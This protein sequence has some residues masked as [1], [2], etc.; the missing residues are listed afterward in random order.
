MMKESLAPGLSHTH[1]YTVSP[2]KTVPHLY[3]EAEELQVMPEV[4]AT[5]YLVGLLEWACIRAINPFIDWPQE[6]TV[7][8]RIDI[9]HLAA[10][11]PGCEITA[12]VKLIEVDGKKLVFDVEAH[13]GID[14][15]CKGRHE[16]YL[17][18]KQKFDQRVETKHR[19][20][21]G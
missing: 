3:P 11:P 12:T 2:T 10:T 6:Q 20:R 4:F 15:I 1:R 9:S 13:D 5:G 17:I 18:N 8:I 19:Q 16:R 7:G 14:L 21:T